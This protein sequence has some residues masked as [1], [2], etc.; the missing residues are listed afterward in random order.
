MKKQE[1][2]DTKHVHTHRQ[3]IGTDGMAGARLRTNSTTSVQRRHTVRNAKVSW[4]GWCTEIRKG[5]GASGGWG[6][7]LEKFIDISDVTKEASR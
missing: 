5:K 3:D 7:D 2:D 1:K 4:A 6:S